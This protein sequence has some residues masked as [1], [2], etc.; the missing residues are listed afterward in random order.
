MRSGLLFSIIVSIVF[1][2]PVL[3][4]DWSTNPGDGSEANPYQ[5]STPEQLIAIGSLNTTG[6]Y[7]DLINDIVFDPNSNPAHIFEFPVI[8]EFRGTLNGNDYTIYNFTI[9]NDYYWFE[10]GF[11]VHKF[12]I[13]KD[14]NFKNANI[15]IGGDS[16]NVGI[17]CGINGGWIENCSAQGE[18]TMDGRCE[19]VGGLVG[20]NIGG[21][22]NCESSVSIV[23][24][25]DDSYDIGILCGNNNGVIENCSAHGQITV[26]GRCER[27]GGLVGGNHF[28]V[29]NSKSSASIITIGDGSYDIGILCGA[30]EGRIEECS[31]LG[32]ITGDGR[33]ERVGGLIGGNYRDVENCNSSVSISNTTYSYDIGGLV[34]YNEGDILCSEA[35]GDIGSLGSL[36]P[37]GPYEYEK[38]GT[39]GLV[40]TN[41][42]GSILGC[43][44]AGDVFGDY[45]IGGLIGY[46]EGYI[47]D[48]SAIGNV[49]IGYEIG[50][51]FVGENRG[52]IL[53][54]LSRG[55]LLGLEFLGGFAGVNDGRISNCYSTGSVTVPS[56]NEHG[57]IYPVRGLGG[58][59]S[60]NFGTIENSYSAGNVFADEFALDNGWVGG[61]IA[62][63][64]GNVEDCFWDIELQAYG[65]TESIGINDGGVIV[66]TTGL[67]T[68]LMQ[69]RS[70]FEGAG[71]YFI[72]KPT[73]YGGCCRWYPFEED[74]WWIDEAKDY[75]RLWFEKN[76]PPV[77]D[78]GADQRVF[79]FGVGFVDVQ[80]DGTGSSDGDNDPL[81]YFW[82]NDA[83]ELIA[84]GAEPN[85]L[86]G[87]GEHVIDLVVNDG[88]EDS[89]PDSCV[90]MVIEAIETE[91]K[92]TPQVLNR[93][94]GRPAVIGR[95]EFV[96]EAMPV[97]DP[98][99]PM[100]LLAG[101]GQ[102]EDQRRMLDYSKKED[103]W[104]LMGFFDNAALMEAIDNIQNPLP[105]SGYSPLAGGELQVTIV[106]KLLTGQWVYGRDSVT[107]K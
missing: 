61:F 43:H 70:T 34:G 2:A 36:G 91:A 31:V 22:L 95:I 6:V 20:G 10:G 63:N 15:S 103:A 42:E 30:N 83:N 66:N 90:V 75:P 5:I 28:E 92:L 84:T 52:R 56:P 37:S 27:V 104:Y 19:G 64:A 101:Q 17:L 14:L 58:F 23:M 99:E 41:L 105:P 96:G 107:V 32:Q 68:I 13:I 39:G 1:C 33:Y 74:V 106:A 78:A 9:V 50:G 11:I 38:S 35:S 98:N 67:S 82:Y 40:G 97:L 46:N 12:G 89:E 55:S 65:V 72:N 24:K 85:V 69:Q 88:I 51:G 45:K 7:F 16:F 4:Y 87:V 53:A 60:I 8:H 86:L 73:N 79:A 3:A 76:T 81:E 25:G 54:S 44:A 57:D 94:S 29:L 100:V 59:S 48:S 62:G 80:L 49:L 26:D 71:W 18:I 47:S 102:I 77:A 93:D 21:L